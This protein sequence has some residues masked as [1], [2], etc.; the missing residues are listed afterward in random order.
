MSSH[1]AVERAHSRTMLVGGR[2]IAWQTH[3]SSSIVRNPAY[4]AAISR[5]GLLVHSW[6]FPL[7]AS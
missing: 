2:D 6:R 7:V 5:F 3:H 1:R 4:G